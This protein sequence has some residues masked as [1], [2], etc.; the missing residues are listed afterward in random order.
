MDWF[1]KLAATTFLLLIP[2]FAADGADKK[3]SKNEIPPPVVKAFELAYPKAKIKEAEIK[4][5]DG[6]FFYQITAEKDRL[7]IEAIFAIE[8]TVAKVEEEIPKQQ[9]PTEIVSKLKE[10]HPEAAIEKAEKVIKN[11]EVIYFEIDMKDKSRKFEVK[12]APDG[13]IIEAE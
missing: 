13:Q 10:L 4:E 8:V 6:K 1:A 11:G 7:E 3:I 5:E 2:F 9:L 12:I